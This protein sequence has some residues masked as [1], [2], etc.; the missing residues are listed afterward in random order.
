MKWGKSWLLRALAGLFLCAC[1]RVGFDLNDLEVGDDGGVADADLADSQVFDAASADAMGLPAW[2][3]DAYLKA[4]NAEAGDLW[5][6]AVALSGDGTTLVVGSS[7]ESSVAI[8]VGGDQADNTAPAAGAVYVFALTAGVWTQE[9]YIKA[10]NTEGADFFGSA[11]S[12]SDD[13]SLLAVNAY[14]ESSSAT[15]VGGDDSDNGAS[16]SGAVY[17]FRRNNTIWNQETYFKAS[18]TNVDDHFGTSLSLSGDGSTLAVGAQFEASAA[19][20]VDGDQLDNSL[21]GA[22]AVYVFVRG[23]GPWFQEAYLKA[24]NT[25]AGDR[26]GSSLSLSDD[27]TILAVGAHSEASAATGVGGDEA[28][29]SAANAGAAYVFVRPLGV[30]GGWIQQAYL[31]AS[32]TE[33]NDFFGISVAVSG[34]GSTLAVGAYLESSSA[35]GVNGDQADNGAGDSGAVYVFT[36]SGNLWIQEAYLKASNTFGFDFFGF[37]LS[38]SDDGNMLAVGSPFEDGNA[39]GVDGDGSDHSAIRSGAA[40]VFARSAGQ[41]MQ[42]AYVKASNTNDDDAFGFSVALSDDGRQLVVGAQNEGSAAT[43]VDGDQANNSA[44]SAGAAYSFA[45]L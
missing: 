31:K 16:D 19:T 26:F 35:T 28:N 2:A 23:D 14:A 37:K 38:M 33:A 11:L 13:G 42:Q 45:D 17:L 32:N 10:S 36:R 30:G 20:G 7:N 12:L 21:S 25:D 22:G 39:T 24:S 3:Q 6:E 15:G 8:G 43:G 41:W 27:G 9:A 40:Y 34:D 29:D 5:G 18:N 4:S 1:G 44:A